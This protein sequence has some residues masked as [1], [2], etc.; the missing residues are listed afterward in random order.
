MGFLAYLIPRDNDPSRPIA[1]VDER[2]ARKA[3]QR[4]KA[5]MDSGEYHRAHAPL[6]A[7][8]SWLRYEITTGRKSRKIQRTHQLDLV[9]MHLAEVR[10]RL[11]IRAA[12]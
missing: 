3:Q 1:V 10:A 5:A 9:E 2:T 4:A 12:C 7:L 11:G 8:Q 6:L